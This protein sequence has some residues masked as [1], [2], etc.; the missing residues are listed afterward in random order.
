MTW[1]ITKKNG[2]RIG[3]PLVVLTVA[4]LA[5]GY[6]L[7]WFSTLADESPDLPAAETTF[8][9]AEG[10][11]IGVASGDLDQPPTEAPAS[12]V[13]GASSSQAQPTT[14]EVAA[15][16][17]DEEPSPAASATASSL[18]TPTTTDEPT[19]AD[20]PA[21]TKRMIVAGDGAAL[22]EAP[23]PDAAAMDLLAA[24]TTATVLEG[25]ILQDGFAWYRW[26]VA[27]TTGWA[28]GASLSPA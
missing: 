5:G 16:P 3:R 8:A 18:M 24:G 15:T 23:R 26:D 4:A 14:A 28:T 1:W 2:R 9:P 10:S 22:R 11:P 20:E 17:A 12:A 25:P 13:G 27:G 6:L 19:P 21:A 7:G